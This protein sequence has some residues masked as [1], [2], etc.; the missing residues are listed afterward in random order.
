MSLAGTIITVADRDAWLAERR[1]GIGASECAA[2]MGISPY[3]G[4]TPLNLYLRKIGALGPTPDNE[5]MKMGRLLEP[6]VAELYMERHDCSFSGEQVFLRSNEHSFM[7]A[8]LDRVRSDGRIV[9]LK[10]AGG[11]SHEDWGPDGTDEVPVNYAA[12]VQHQMLVAETDTADLAVLIGGQQ[13]RTYTLHRNERQ[14]AEIVRREA[15][16]WEHVETRTPPEIR[17]GD[18]RLMHRLYDRV[19]GEIDLDPADSLLVEDWEVLGKRISA[20]EKRRNRIKLA[21]LERLGNVAAA[22][23][24]DGRV[25]TRKVV[26]VPGRVSTTEGYEFTDIRLK[27]G[28]T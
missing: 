9:E 28:R 18:L 25:L 8:T 3:E 10:T 15:I 5:A 14:I 1:S 20:A 27:K 24:A 12:Q 16:F 22:K 21:I 23:L 2:A 11:R 7:L 17:E 6:I 19:D 13:F 4:D 26:V